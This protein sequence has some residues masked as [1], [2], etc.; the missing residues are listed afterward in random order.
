[1]GS[2]KAGGIAFPEQG[3]APAG[4]QKKTVPALQAAVDAL[5]PNSGDWRVE[6]VPGLYVRV[7]A[8][9]R[10]YRIQRRIDGRLVVEVLGE[11][12]V[13]QAR[14]KAMETWAA[15][16]PPP[17]HGRM[18]L[19]EAWQRYLSEK[20]LAESTRRLYQ[21]NGER[22][23]K[24]WLGRSLEEVGMDRDGVRAL[25]QELARPMKRVLPEEAS[26]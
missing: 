25:H 12:T 6:G 16:K 21:Y 7:G 23:L 4:N 14:R 15:L 20:P 1:M 8:Q 24:A 2:R 5:P 10:S 22:Y 13:A 11:M 26:M 3:A 9:G 19:G 17:V 18:T